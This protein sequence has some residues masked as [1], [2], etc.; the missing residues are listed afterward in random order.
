MGQVLLH[1]ALADAAET[2]G[3]LCAAPD[4]DA[5]AT[6]QRAFASTRRTKPRRRDPVGACGPRRGRYD[7]AGRGSVVGSRSRRALRCVL[8]R[9]GAPVR[10]A[11]PI[12]PRTGRGPAAAAGAKPSA[13]GPRRRRGWT[14][15]GHL[16]GTPAGTVDCTTSLVWI[17]EVSWG[18]GFWGVDTLTPARRLGVGTDTGLG[19]TRGV[20]AT[21]RLRRGCGD[22]SRRRRGRSTLIF[23][24]G[25]AAGA[26]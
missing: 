14:V 6:G 4:A 9:A 3:V 17:G 26:P 25:V 21:P 23:A 11:N 24:R 16:A 8:R 2:V 10:N 18:R 20:A 5:V 12:R 15:R 1:G 7:D 22:E 13:D 19:Q